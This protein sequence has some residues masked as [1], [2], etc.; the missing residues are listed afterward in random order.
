MTIYERIV[1]ALAIFE[2]ARST[3]PKRSAVALAKIHSIHRSNLTIPVY[4]PRSRST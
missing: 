4:K 1:S 2:W 3:T